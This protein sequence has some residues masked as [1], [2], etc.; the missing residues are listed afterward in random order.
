MAIAQSTFNLTDAQLIELCNMAAEVS[1][2]TSIEK[3]ELK[4]KIEAFATAHDVQSK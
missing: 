4:A 2:A 1:F 3:S